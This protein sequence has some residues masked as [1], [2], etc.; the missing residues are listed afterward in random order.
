[1]KE[2]SAEARLDTFLAAYTPEVRELADRVLAKMRKRLPGAFQLVYDNYNALVVTFGASER[3]ADIVCS[4][5]LYPRWV[6]LFFL[7]GATLPDPEKLLVGSGK[8][9]RSVV[10]A[11]EELLDTRGVRDLLKHAVASAPSMLRTRSGELLVIQSVS[12]KK[13]PRRPAQVSRKR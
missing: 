5:A 4:I 7:H 3:P 2:A 6:T 13:R 10:L 9:I 12:A 11:S 1:M 8:T